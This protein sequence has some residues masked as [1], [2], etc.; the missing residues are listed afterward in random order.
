MVM[1]FVCAL[2]FLFAMSSVA[3]ES[4]DIFISVT[5]TSFDSGGSISRQCSLSAES[6]LPMAIIAPQ[7]NPP[8]FV[9]A[10]IR[11][12][13]NQT[14]LQ[15]GEASRFADYVAQD[16]LLDGVV[17]LHGGEIVLEAYPNMRPW[18]R[19]FAWASITVQDIAK[20]LVIEAVAGKP[21]AL[22]LQ[23]LVS[24][25]IESETDA[26]VAISK[27]G[28]ADSSVGLYTR[29]LDIARFGQIYWQPKLS[30]VLA[31]ATINTMLPVSR[32]IAREDWRNASESE[33]SPIAHIAR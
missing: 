18:Q 31:K 21:Y 26:L 27:A 32:Q 11:A 20:M 5:P 7:N 2:A 24:G 1:L 33:V 29:L 10:P 23:E 19:H 25:P 28:Y 17:V 8:A 30:G 4:K 12:L 15:K 3:Q 14:I 22:A 6:Y 13:A 16:K 9:V